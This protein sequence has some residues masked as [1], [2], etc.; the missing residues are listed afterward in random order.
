MCILCPFIVEG[1]YCDVLSGTEMCL[2]CPSLKVF[3]VMW[4][5]GVHPFNDTFE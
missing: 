3:I 2:L 1:L 4:V 5:C